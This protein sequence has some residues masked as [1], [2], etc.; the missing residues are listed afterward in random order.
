MIEI[1]LQ[2]GTMVHYCL[3]LDFCICGSPDELNASI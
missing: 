1:D 3:S 2:T